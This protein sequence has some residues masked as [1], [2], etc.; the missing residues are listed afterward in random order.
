MGLAMLMLCAS[1]TW[2]QDRASNL[3]RVSAN[4]TVSQTIGITDVAI[5]YGR[6]LVNERTIYGDLVPYDQVWR[7]GANEAT[8]I[9]FSHDVTIEGQALAAGTYALFAIPH[10]N[11]WTVI[12]NKTANQWGAFSY[13][14]GEDALRVK[15]ASQTMPHH[16]L[17]TMAFMDVTSESANL[18]AGWA[19]RGFAVQVGV[20]TKT[21]IMAKAEAEIAETDN[22]QVPMQ[23]AGYAF[24]NNELAK[25]LEWIDKS[26]AIE[27][28]FFNVGGKAQ[29][30]AQMGNTDGAIEL[31]EK[32][33]K[34]AKAM[35]QPPGNLSQF[36]DLLAQWKGNK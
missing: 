5:T 29:A 10:Q 35:P 30:L 32:A 20:D 31:G 4:A 16:E 7:L 19:D 33:L 11:E 15:V 34:M 36:E 24:R 22:W 8:T 21:M 26:I 18:M 13:D 9:T 14:E 23:Y 2:A 6:P 12:F 1:T 28:T 25:A 17:F 27:E 3:P